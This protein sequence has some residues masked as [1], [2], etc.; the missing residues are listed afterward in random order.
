MFILKTSSFLV[1]DRMLLLFFF[2][3]KNVGVWYKDFY[4]TQMILC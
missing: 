2:F 4:K 3:L 1:L